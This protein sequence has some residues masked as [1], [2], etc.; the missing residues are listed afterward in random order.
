MSV[1]IHKTNECNRS[2]SEKST[3]LHLHVSR[4]LASEKC[5]S[6]EN[7]NS[8]TAHVAISCD[9][10]IQINPS[11]KSGDN[12]SWNFPSPPTG[13][14]LPKC[15]PFPKCLWSN[16]YHGYRFPYPNAYIS[17]SPWVKGSLHRLGTFCQTPDA[18]NSILS[19]SQW[20]PHLDEMDHFI[21]VDNFPIPHILWWTEHGNVLAGTSIL[22]FKAD[23]T[24]WTNDSAY[25]WGAHLEDLDVSGKWS[26][27]EQSL[28]I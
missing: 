11:T 2:A 25:R 27:M 4:R 24:L 20:R 14:G 3:D 5:R 19:M 10:S 23:L 28:Y 21:Q 16:F 8:V 15:G 9:E 13:Y 6:N 22:T 18:S 26:V 1:R 12:L 17:Q 7:E